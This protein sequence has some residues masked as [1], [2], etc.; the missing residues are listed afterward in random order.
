M[1]KCAKCDQK[2]PIR[3]GY[4]KL[5]PEES[6]KDYCNL[7]FNQTKYAT[8]IEESIITANETKERCIICGD[9]SSDYYELVPSFYCVRCYKAATLHKRLL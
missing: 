3:I 5:H 8:D 6:G 1:A 2:G 4:S 7:H 9:I